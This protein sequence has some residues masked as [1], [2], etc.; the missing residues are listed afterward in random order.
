MRTFDGLTP[1]LYIATIA[2]TAGLLGNEKAD[3]VIGVV[4]GLKASEA[5]NA[6]IIQSTISGGGGLAI[7]RVTQTRYALAPE[8]ALAF[9]EQV[10]AGP[11]RNRGC[12]LVGSGSGLHL[13]EQSMQR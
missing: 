11:S 10:P 13:A 2:A 5:K 7:L 8:T 6:A 1:C 9:L 4:G 3:T 12:W